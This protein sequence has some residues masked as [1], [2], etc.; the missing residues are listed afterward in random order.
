MTTSA[1]SPVTPPACRF[2]LSETPSAKL[3]TYRR[4]RSDRYGIRLGDLAHASR[5]GSNRS[6]RRDY[7]LAP[8]RRSSWS[9]HCHLWRIHPTPPYRTGPLPPALLLFSLSSSKGEHLAT[10]Q[11]ALAASPPETGRPNVTG[12]FSSNFTHLLLAH[13]A[14]TLPPLARRLVLSTCDPLRSS[15]MRTST[16]GSSIAQGRPWPTRAATSFAAASAIESADM[17]PGDCTSSF[18]V[19]TSAAGSCWRPLTQ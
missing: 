16:A 19:A 18:G 13:A 12:W 6:W 7:M 11:R 10:D 17:V 9:S 14:S 8:S 2:H 5:S 3:R 1:T 4:R 15:A